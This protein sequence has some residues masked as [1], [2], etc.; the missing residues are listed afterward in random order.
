[1]HLGAGKRGDWRL[2]GLT[3]RYAD[4]VW[5]VLLTEQNKLGQLKAFKEKYEDSE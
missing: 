4:R 1:M 5:S 3:V 2:V